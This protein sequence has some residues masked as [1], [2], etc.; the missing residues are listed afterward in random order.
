MNGDL[1]TFN[2]VMDLLGKKINSQFNKDINSSFAE[3][4]ITLIDLLEAV[5]CSFIN[6]ELGEDDVVND[7]V[8]FLSQRGLLVQFNETYP[9][10]EKKSKE[11]KICKSIL[12]KMHPPNLINRSSQYYDPFALKICEKIN[13]CELPNKKSS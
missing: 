7:L 1:T 12:D 6:N 8:N 4:F 3:G 2:K 9:N 11:I 10:R 13:I 5:S